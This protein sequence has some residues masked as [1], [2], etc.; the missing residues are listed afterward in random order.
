[1]TRRSATDAIL[2][3]SWI[4]K[5]PISSLRTPV[6]HKNFSLSDLMGS[7][8]N[9][10]TGDV[11]QAPGAMKMETNIAARSRQDRRNPGKRG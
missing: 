10:Q 6:I 3:F 2:Y 4:I 7:G 11:M 8:Q 9:L 1:M 5:N